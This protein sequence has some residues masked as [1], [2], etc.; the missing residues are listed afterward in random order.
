ML[1]CQHW[2]IEWGW[3]R[4]QT[5]CHIS[6]F[7]YYVIYPISHS[8][9][10]DFLQCSHHMCSQNNGWETSAGCEVYERWGWEARHSHRNFSSED[11]FWDE[12]VMLQTSP[13]LSRAPHDTPIIY[14]IKGWFRTSRVVFTPKHWISHGRTGSGPSWC[15]LNLRFDFF[16]ASMACWSNPFPRMACWSNPLPRMACWFSVGIASHSMH[17]IDWTRPGRSV[18][19]QSQCSNFPW[20]CSAWLHVFFHLLS[21]WLS[22]ERSAWPWM[23]TR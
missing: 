21:S 23:A 10:F 17:S 22:M 8:L 9:I 16:F 14:N 12:L 1:V 4:G 7:P 11:Y 3:Q 5:R 20:E 18:A 6:Y 15:C 2:T 13:N 19:A